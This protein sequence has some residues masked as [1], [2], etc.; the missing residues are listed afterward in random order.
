MQGSVATSMVLS[1]ALSS[2]TVPLALGLLA[3]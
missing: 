1:T 3:Q 2:L